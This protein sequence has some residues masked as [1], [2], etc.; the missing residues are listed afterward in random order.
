MAEFTIE[1]CDGMPGFVE[2]ELDYWLDTVKSYC[3]WSA[4]LIEIKDY[5]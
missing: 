1:L 2:S 5:R 3:P 4:K